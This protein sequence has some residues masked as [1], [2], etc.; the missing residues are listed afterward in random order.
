AIASVLAVLAS[1][2]R[3]EAEEK[4]VEVERQA[5]QARKNEAEAIAL[6][7]RLE[8][9]LAQSL[10]RPLGL[11]GREPLTY[12]EIEAFWELASSREERLSVRFV[13]E[14]SARPGTARQLTDRAEFALHAAVGLDI[15]RRKQVEIL[16]WQ[17]L[18]SAE[19]NLQHRLDLALAVSRLPTPDR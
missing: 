12:P 2:A 1:E 7:G 19:L 17:R 16:L 13:E 8:Q 5:E 10:L 3:G 4:T 15:R 9:A 14:A 6:S 11:K 18:G